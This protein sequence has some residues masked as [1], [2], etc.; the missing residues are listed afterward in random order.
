MRMHAYACKTVRCRTGFYN[1]WIGIKYYR[2]VP[3]KTRESVMVD[4]E[5]TIVSP[6]LVQIATVLHM[7]CLWPVA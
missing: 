2:V 6:C 7:A 1:F 3:D 4:L 5:E